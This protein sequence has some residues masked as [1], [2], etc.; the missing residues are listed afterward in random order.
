MLS[1]IW[2]LC[3]DKY[4]HI[5]HHISRVIGKF[6]LPLIKANK[7]SYA[8]YLLQHSTYIYKT[9]MNAIST[10]LCEL[11]RIFIFILYMFIMPV[12]LVETD[13]FLGGGEM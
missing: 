5:I 12:N 2:G 4:E 8:L 7:F 9:C 6:V 3:Y 10:Y 11:I 13:D 1:S